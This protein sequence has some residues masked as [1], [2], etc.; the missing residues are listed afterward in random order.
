M[1][2]YK[3][4][5]PNGVNDILCGECAVKREIETTIQA[6]F[7][8]LGYRE[9]ET[10]M[11]EYYDCYIGRRGQISQENLYKFFDE[12]GRILV[13]RPDFTTSIARMSAT[14]EADLPSPLRYMYTGSVFRAEL[15]EGA[16][17]RE[18][19]Q[20]GIELI[21]SSS[22][23]ADAE[24]I[25]AAIEAVTAAGIGEMTVEIG[26]VAF[27]NGL[28]EQ[29][30]LSPD[31]TER[32][33][34]RIDSKDVVGI[35]EIL[36]KLD[37]DAE[38]KSVIEALPYMFGDIAILDEADVPALNGTSRAALKNLRDIYAALCDYGCERYVSLDLGML[39]SIDYYTGSIFK[40]YTRGVGF[41][42]C[43]GGRYDNLMGNFGSP[44]EA[45]GAAIGINRL[46]TALD[47]PAD[48]E[49]GVMMMYAEENAYAEAYGLSASLRDCGYIVENYIGGGAYEDAVTLGR[50]KNIACILRVSADGRVVIHD[51]KTD[52]KT[53]T[54]SDEFEYDAEDLK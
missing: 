45:V 15:T 11:F 7:A 25:A 23:R 47:R 1:S 35:R 44:K 53:E 46:M 4:H 54:T 16:R 28:A 5:T 18:F 32:L 51:L 49:R 31:E 52:K 38:I 9:A 6:T 41:P 24:V 34:A 37:I 30:G 36:K 48:T 43:A 12:Q 26:Q 13:L 27:F 39:Q 40:I 29:A 42:I 14:K 20:S 3:L 10:P 19:T 8:S 33:R 2:D 22:P 17:R 21:G 50:A